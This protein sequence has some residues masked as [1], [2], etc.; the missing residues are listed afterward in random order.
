MHLNNN[1]Y[2]VQKKLRFCFCNIIKFI[3]LPKQANCLLYTPTIW[4]KSRIIYI[5]HVMIFHKK[6]Q[7]NTN[8]WNNTII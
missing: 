2:Y 7:V 8:K 5:S 3:Y 4:T 1:I 6:Q